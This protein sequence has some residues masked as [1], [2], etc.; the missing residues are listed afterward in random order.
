MEKTHMIRLTD[1]ERKIR[2]ETIDRLKGSS[3]KV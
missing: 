3:Q 1:E 2:N